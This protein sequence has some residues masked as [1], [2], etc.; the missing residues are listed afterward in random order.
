MITD[1]PIYVYITFFISVVFSVYMIYLASNKN[2]KLLLGILAISFIASALAIA[3]FFEKTEGFPPRINLAFAPGLLFIFSTPFIPSLRKWIKGFDLKT[4]TYLSTVRIPVEIILFWLF[5][6]GYIPEVMT[7]E[8]RNFDIIAGI[9]API[10]GYFAFRN[11]VVNRKLLIG[12]NVISLLLLFNI[13][14]HATLAI[15]TVI[16]Q[17]AF[18]QPNIMVLYFPTILLPMI[19]V[20]IV[21]FTHIISLTQLLGSEEESKAIKEMS[22]L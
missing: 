17:I 22:I 14:V 19:I 21:M 11:G 4:M 18:D 8:G 13:V 10:V 2:A 3:G 9:T 7:F 16:Q 12:W 15:P 5:I 1:L 20:P 6:A